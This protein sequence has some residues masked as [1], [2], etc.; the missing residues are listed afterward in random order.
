M[1]YVSYVELNVPDSQKAAEFFK[2]VFGWDAQ[3]WD[4]SGYMVVDNGEEAGIG[5]GIDNLK[6]GAMPNAVPVIAVESVDKAAKEL[7]A[8]GGKI[9][10][11]KMAIPGTGYA[12]SF[13]TPGGLTMSI[14]EADE[15]AA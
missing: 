8:A 6:D 4:D 7:V 12:A 9:T 5:A 11:P 1:P 10:V 2:K 13:T 15:K 14:Y 3:S